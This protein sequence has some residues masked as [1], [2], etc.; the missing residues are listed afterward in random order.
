MWGA[1]AALT[2]G[3]PYYLYADGSDYPPRWTYA[4]KEL[5]AALVTNAKQTIYGSK[6][7]FSGD[8]EQYIYLDVMRESGISG[9]AMQA[10]RMGMRVHNID[11]HKAPSIYQVA[12]LVERVRG[13]IPDTLMRTL[14]E[15]LREFDRIS[16]SLKLTPAQE[17]KTNE[18]VNELTNLRNT[19]EALKDR[20]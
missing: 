5:A 8:V 20:R 12:A 6:M 14:D 9:P 1:Q 10:I 2:A 11:P 18:R 15:V 17:Q 4:Q 7:D 3:I 13:A 19:L 16:N